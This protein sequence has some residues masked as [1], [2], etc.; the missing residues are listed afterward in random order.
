[1][2]YSTQLSPAATV[3]KA[4]CMLP[5]A[6][7]A[8]TGAWATGGDVCSKTANTLLTACGS[9]TNDN[10]FVSTATC[11]NLADADARKECLAEAKATRKDDA[12]S[13][14]EVYHARLDVC[15]ALATDGPYNPPF[16]T[17]Y[18]DNFVNPLEIGSTVAANPYFPLVKDNQWKYLTNY[19]DENGED[20]TEK[21]TVTVTDRTKLIEG[22][23]CVVVTDV[24][25]ASDGT[26]EKTEDW[27]TQ[28]V[29]G[30]VW[31]CGESSQQKET[32]DGDNPPRPELVSIDGSWK[33]GREG[34]KPG[35][36]MYANPEVGKTYRQE[37]AWVEAEDVAK[38]LATNAD[39]SAHNGEFQCKDMCV[40]TRD[41][42]ALEPD[43]NEH[44]YYAPGVGLMLEV[45]LTNGA[46]NELVSYTHP[47][48]P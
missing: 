18:K 26:V 41:Y 42:T 13:C 16:G 15:D 14:H 25:R 21:D 23:T 5:V 29:Q 4:A 39:E 24:V 10:Y 45:D 9:D 36:Q 44:K 22:V 37:L 3:L 20:I 11:Q 40:E 48:M 46:R 43:A 17:D 1:M 27:Y 19:K 34:A 35:I 7:F 47:N 32:F 38:V 33:T 8:S 31:Y 12:S 28:D 6:L 2:T 30:N